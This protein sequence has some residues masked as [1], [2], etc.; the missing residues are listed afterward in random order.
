MRHTRSS[1]ALAAL[2]RFGYGPRSGEPDPTAGDP[3]GWLGAQARTE[4]TPP[5]PIAR[6]QGSQA[7][8]ADFQ[9]QVMDGRRRRRR[10]A[11]DGDVAERVRRAVRGQAVPAYLAQVD[12]RVRTAVGSNAPFHERLVHFW[13]NHFAVSADKPPTVAIAGTLEFEAVRPNVARRFTDLLLTV[14]RHPAMITYLDNQRSVGPNSRAARLAGLFRRELDPGINENLAREILEL[15]T[16]G[17]DGGYT[18]A[19]VTELAHVLTGWSVGG[20]RGVLA[21]GEPGRFTFREGIHEP[22]ERRVLGR[23]YA[24]DGE[25]QGVAVLRDLARHPATARHVSLKLARHFVADE[26]PPDLVEMLAS[27]FLETDGDLPAVYAALLA[28]PAA[29]AGERAKFKTPNDYLLSALRALDFVP[30]ESRLL[31]GS[32]EQLGQRPWAPGSP[33]G[34]PDRA[35]R[36][37]GA[38]QLMKRIEWAD[39]VA[40][41][42]PEVPPPDALADHAL[43]PALDDHTRLAVARAETDRQAVTLLL[44]SPEFQWR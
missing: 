44:A 9:A 12:A 25:A 8:L 26:P 13:A 4:A 3:V 36:W 38:D 15:H 43:A 40:R 23:R 34:W 18:Q 39:T 42:L 20:G 28:H 31:V 16:L 11:D 30:D 24:E 32:F 33:A 37:N 19:D 14:V 6:L 17:V 22:G 10:A 21:A 35:A 2:N 27:T 5:A 41:H 29:L 1:E 7:L